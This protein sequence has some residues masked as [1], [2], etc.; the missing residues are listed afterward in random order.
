MK[1][2]CQYPR[3]RNPSEINYLGTELCQEHFKEVSDYREQYCFNCKKCKDLERDLKID[4]I[5]KCI[6]DNKNEKM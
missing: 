1:D 5:V 3:C 4:E 2:K 6:G